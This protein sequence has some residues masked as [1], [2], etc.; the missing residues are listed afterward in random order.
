[1]HGAAQWGTLGQLVQGNT[2]VLMPR[3]DAEEV[4]DI[5]EREG[6][7]SMLIAGDA[8]GRPMIEALE[9]EPD[10][11][12]LSSLFAVTSSA[13]LFSVPVKERYFE[14]LP[15]LMIIDSIGSSEGGF[16]GLSAVGKDNPTG[17]SS[18]GLPRVSPMADV[19]VVDD[20]LNPLTPGDG[21]VGKVARGGNI[22][23]GYYK[24]EEKTAEHVPGRPR[25]Q[26][27]RGRRRLRPLGGR[28]HRHAARP[29]LGVHQLRRREDLPRGGRGR[30]EVAPRRVRRPRRRRA[31]RALGLGGHRRGAAHARAT[32]PTLDDLDDRVPDE[33]RRL[34]AAPPPRA[35]STRSSAPPPASP[36]TPGPPSTPPRSSPARPD[37]AHRPSAGRTRATGRRTHASRLAVRCS[38][39]WPAATGPS[40]ASTSHRTGFNP[41]EHAIT[42]ANAASLEIDV[43]V[44][45]LHAIGDRPL[46]QPASSTR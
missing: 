37:S 43:D 39:C 21:Q 5:V 12:D 3:F 16:N 7:N 23:L 33:A 40:P 41:H 45:G 32:T 44:P 46:A 20:D 31:R 29:R 13:A 34:Q 1:M 24:D 19:I 14:R 42:A 4:W 9:A 11:W 26:A 15:N 25:R 38:L 17:G 36:T 27:L 28:R 30:A 6:V 2:I 10:R 18:G 35:W 22:P 8:M